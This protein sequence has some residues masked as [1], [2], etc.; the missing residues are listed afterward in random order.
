MFERRSVKKMTKKMTRDEQGW[1]TLSNQ[2]VE[3]EEG[4]AEVE[5]Q[6]RSTATPVFQTDWLAPAM[7]VVNLIVIA[8]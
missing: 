1:T 8:K 4:G 6:E 7:S 3:A 5:I 2:M